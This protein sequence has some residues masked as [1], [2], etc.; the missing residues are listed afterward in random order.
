MRIVVVGGGPAGCAVAVVARRLGYEVVLLDNDRRPATWPGESVP[1]GGGELI[2]SVFGSDVLSG[3]SV[4]YGTAA[5]WGSDDLVAHDFMAHWSGHGWHLDRSRFDDSLRDVARSEGAEVVSTHVAAIGGQPGA[6][7]V[8]DKWSA[9]WLVDATGRAG[10]VSAR[11]G[12]EM[13]RCDDQVALIRTVPDAGGER[14]T[15]VESGPCGWWYST[16]LPQGSRVAAL[17]TDADLVGGDRDA[18]WTRALAATRHISSLV[19]DVADSRTSAYPAGTAYRNPIVGDGW[20]AVGDA[21]VSFDP[22][23]SQGLITGIVM[24]A[25]AATMLGALDEWVADYVA[26]RD[27]H[28]QARSEILSAETRWADAPFWARRR[29]HSACG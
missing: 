3:S 4:A 21:A 14:V 18:A 9:E 29:A 28:L 1:A 20:L 22:L 15:T 7:V 26:V 6:W 24:A 10:A 13:R 11:L 19:G 23:S 25:R 27:E 2:A 12:S 5:A 8:N 17:I 16:P